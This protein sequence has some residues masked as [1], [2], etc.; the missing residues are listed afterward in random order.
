MKQFDIR[1]LDSRLMDCVPG[2][3]TP[4]SAGIDLRACINERTEIR[5]GKRC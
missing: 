5:P 3:A 4:G 2:Y 1:L